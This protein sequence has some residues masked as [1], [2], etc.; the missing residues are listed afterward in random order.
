M[1]RTRSRTR[2]PVDDSD[3]DYINNCRTAHASMPGKL[4]FFKHDGGSGKHFL[5][6]DL[7]VALAGLKWTSR[8]WGPP[9][10]LR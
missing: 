6:V 4:N 7:A 9:A 8:R 2:Y 5:G 1:I 3:D 10:F